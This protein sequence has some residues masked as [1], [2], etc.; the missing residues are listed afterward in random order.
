MRSTA[1]TYR[2]RSAASFPMAASACSTTTSP[3][4][5]A[6]S[7]SARRWSWRAD[8]RDPGKTTGA[9]SLDAAFLS[10]EAPAARAPAVAV[11]AI[12]AARVTAGEQRRRNVGGSPGRDVGENP[13]VFVGAKVGDRHAALAEQTA[14]RAGSGFGLVQLLLAG[15]FHLG[16][17]DATQANA[18]D[19]IAAVAL[20]NA[21]E[22]GVAVDGANDVDRLTHIGS[23]RLLQDDLGIS[24]LTVRRVWNRPVRAVAKGEHGRHHDADHEH[25]RQQSGE[26]TAERRAAE[27]RP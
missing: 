10:P 3:I 7:P 18:H 21:R 9:A 26:A 6:A 19:E 27:P 12:V 11:A 23:P 15:R 2:A 24:R 17:I 22:K 8:R 4:S 14:Q 20:T 16:C 13:T 5:T 1:P 25:P